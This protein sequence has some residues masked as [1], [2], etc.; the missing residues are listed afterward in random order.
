[1]DNVAPAVAMGINNPTPAISR[2]GVANSLT[3]NQQH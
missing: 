1:M 3:T 2:Y